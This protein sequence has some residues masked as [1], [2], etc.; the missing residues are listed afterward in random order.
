MA[1][2]R[3][4]ILQP[5]LRDGYAGMNGVKRFRFGGGPCALLELAGE[6]WIPSA[7]EAGIKIDCLRRG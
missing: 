4:Q 6:F 7:A 3:G 2:F 5:F 1:G